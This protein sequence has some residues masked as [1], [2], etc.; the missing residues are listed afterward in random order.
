M[1]KQI[2][3]ICNKKSFWN[4]FF[5]LI[6]IKN[7]FF[8]FTFI[9]ILLNLY[10][11]IL[12]F[13]SYNYFLMHYF[14]FIFIHSLVYSFLYL[15]IP[16]CIYFQIYSLCN[17]EMRKAVLEECWCMVKSSRIELSIVSSVEIETGVSMGRGRSTGELSLS[18]LIIM[19][20][21]YY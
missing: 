18:F 1:I 14:I 3:F 17:I 4:V 2:L 8:V 12:S 10:L 6:L 5:L 13:I 16:K 9:F 21:Y 11:L 15:F 7:T 20:S 19:F